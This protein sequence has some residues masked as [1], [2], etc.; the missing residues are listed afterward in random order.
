MNTNS[1]TKCILLAGLLSWCCLSAAPALAQVSYGY[2]YGWLYNP[3]VQ[4]ELEVVDYQLEQIKELQSKLQA[5]TREIYAEIAKLPREDQSAEYQ[6]A[7][8]KVQELYKDHNAKLKKILLPQQID[9]LEQISAQMQLRGGAAYGLRGAL[10]EKLGLSEQQ[11]TELKEK[12]AEKNRELYAKY[13]ELKAEM[14]KE[15]LDEVLT[16]K[17]RKQLDDL[18]GEPIDLNAWQGAARH[19]TAGQGG[20]KPSNSK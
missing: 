12:A 18:I 14:E 2:G 11:Q 9:R 4:K 10:A 5:E 6:E 3:Q 15:L 7:Q 19:A 8:K 17:Q 1:I 20:A 16:A 13:A